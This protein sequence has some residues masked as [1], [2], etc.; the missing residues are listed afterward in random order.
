MYATKLILNRTNGSCT[1]VVNSL[2]ITL[3]LLPTIFSHHTSSVIVYYSLNAHQQTSTATVPLVNY[4]KTHA[5]THQFTN[6]RCKN[7]V[8][9]NI[10]LSVSPLLWRK[11]H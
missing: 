6:Q 11:T 3:L 2:I 5:T 9:Y 4:V 8:L 10:L 7:R 1:L